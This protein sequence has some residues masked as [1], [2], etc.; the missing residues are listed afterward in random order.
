[1]LQSLRFN[2]TLSKV[3]QIIVLIYQTIAVAIFMAA[4]VFAY[5]WLQKPFLG[6]FFEPTMIMSPVGPRS[7]SDTWG[8]YNQGARYDNQLIS[9]SGEK[10]SNEIGRAHV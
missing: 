6:A 1:M 10:I 8:L 2:L 5:N 9:V 3:L 4:L 7:S